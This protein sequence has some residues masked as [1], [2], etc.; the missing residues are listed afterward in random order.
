LRN[1]RPLFGDF[2]KKGKEKVGEGYRRGRME[3]GEF[4]GEKSPLTSISPERGRIYLYQ[5]GRNGKKG[6]SLLPHSSGHN[7]SWGFPRIWR[8]GQILPPETEN[9]KKNPKNF[10]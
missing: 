3:R 10:N 9:S 7:W 5:K 2:K 1:W 4:G 8:G 6:V